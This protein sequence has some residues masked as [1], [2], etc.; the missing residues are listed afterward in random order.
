[1]AKY[2]PI[3]TSVWKDPDFEKY[4]PLDKLVFLYLCTNES[5][6]ESGIYPITI[7]T[8]S[9]ETGISCETVG[10]Q[11]ANSL[12]NIVYDF[13]NSFVFVK[14]FLKYNG[15][16]RPD[17][18]RKSISKNYELYK[19]PLWNEFIELYP[20]YSDNIEPINISNTN[21][22]SNTIS[23]ANTNSIEQLANGLQTVGTPTPKIKYAD[24]VLLTEE[25]HQKLITQYGIDNT[26]AF[27]NKLNAYK[28]ANGKKYKSDY[29]AVLSWVVDEILNKGGAKNENTN[30][31]AK[32]FENERLDDTEKAGFFANIT[33]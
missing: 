19:T 33:N 15:G 22:N 17:L 5:T 13:D 3:Y 16:G 29:L 23:N 31:S 12:K 26:K 28:G 11:L 10:K 6:T 27:I 21:T 20:E 8:I 14:K 18:L 32:R 25:E 9:N 7:K 4:K 1:M 2:R 24:Y 30:R